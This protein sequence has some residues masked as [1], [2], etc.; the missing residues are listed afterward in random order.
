MN[1]WIS[2]GYGVYQKKFIGSNI[3][4][5]SDGH[6]QLFNRSKG[7]PHVIYPN[8]MKAVVGDENQRAL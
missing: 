6:I 1:G 8:G 7:E 4:S 3:R 2:M 5:W